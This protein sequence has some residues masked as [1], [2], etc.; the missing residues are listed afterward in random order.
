MGEVYVRLAAGEGLEAFTAVM[1]VRRK[2][3]R[4][5]NHA[6]VFATLN[7]VLCGV[8]GYVPNA[9]DGDVAS[10]LE[11]ALNYIAV[12]VMWEPDASAGPTARIEVGARCDEEDTAFIVVMGTLDCAARSMVSVD[13]AV[14][15]GVEVTPGVAAHAAHRVMGMMQM[16]RVRLMRAV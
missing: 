2:T 10:R 1:K 7:R 13:I 8:I 3:M 6:E 9:D 16:Q 11:D 15:D 4:E 14:R 5:Q 12:D